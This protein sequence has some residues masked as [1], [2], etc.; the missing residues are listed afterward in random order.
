MDAI[1]VEISRITVAK[2]PH[3][4]VCRGVGSC[5]AVALY[6]PHTGIGGLAHPLLPRSNGHPGGNI[7][8]FAD[9]AIM[10]V[11]RDMVSI[12]CRRR[13]IIGKIAGGASIFPSPRG[14]ASIGERN[15][16]SVKEE[17][18]RLSIPVRAEDVGGTQ[19]RSIE[20]HLADGRL[21]VRTLEGMVK[22]L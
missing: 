14:H 9:A 22:L 15:I 21:L 11:I 5:V 13:S 10:S 12:G 20:F 2:S 16:R 18:K 4:L 17:L 3:I 1:K 6:D 19:G 8:R 7:L